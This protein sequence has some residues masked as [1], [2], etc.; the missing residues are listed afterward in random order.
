MATL[1]D[2]G[3]RG[4]EEAGP[5]DSQTLLFD[6][7]RL[8]QPTFHELYLQTPEKFRAELIDG[9]VYVMSSPV[10]PKHG[11]PVVSLGWF[12]YSYRLTT[13]GTIVQG[14]STTKLGPRSEVQPDCALLIDPRFGGQTGEDLKGYT[15][16]CPEL[17]VEISLSTL[18]I[19]LNAKKQVYEE[20][21]A[22][23]YLVY[24]EPHR[25]FHWFALRDGKFEP[26]VMDDDGLY[27]SEAF[28]GL[29]FNSIA[30]LLDDGET[31]L[32]TLRRGLESPDHAAFAARLRENRANRP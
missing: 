23:E 1:D 32:A 12:L 9:V 16:G 25:K 14:D 28:P 27:R 8:D 26:L 2:L 11:R 30:F 13:P 7:Q 17:V 24:D 31:V 15:I 6:G 21:G 22:K 3:S 5:A 19:D 20:A 4:S 18:Q 29:W 10:N